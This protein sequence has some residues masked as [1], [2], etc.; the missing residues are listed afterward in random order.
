MEVRVSEIDVA[1]GRGRVMGERMDWV[2]VLGMVLKEV[3][4][5]D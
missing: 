5:Y 3:S 1:E 4:I 2:F